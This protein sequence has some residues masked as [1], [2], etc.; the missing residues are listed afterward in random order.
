MALYINTNIWSLNA[1]RALATSQAELTR[2]LE[3]LSTTLRINRASDD[4]TGHAITER[5]TSQ[6]NGVDQARRNVSHGTIFAQHAESNLESINARLQEIRTKIVSANEGSLA[7][8]QRQALQNEVNVLLSEVERIAQTAEFDGRKVLNGT[9]TNSVF[10]VGPNAADTV[11]V[12]TNDFRS[13]S[14][15]VYRVIGNASGSGP[16]GKNR[17][18]EKMTVSGALGASGPFD[19]AP[20]GIG[21]GARRIAEQVNGVSS[22]TGVTATAKT[23]VDIKGWVDGTYRLAIESDNVANPLSFDF[24]VKAALP[25][26]LLAFDLSTAVALFNQSDVSLQSGVVMSLNKAYLDGSDSAV[27]GITLTNDKGSNIAISN[28]PASVNPGTKLTISGS[29]DGVAVTDTVT[30]DLPPAE[31]NQRIFTGQVIFDSDKPFSIR[32][33]T[34]DADYTN[35]RSLKDTSATSKFI[36]EQAKVVPIANIDITTLEGVR[37]AFAIVDGA[38]ST[39]AN[40]RASLGSVKNRFDWIISNLDSDFVNLSTARGYIRDADVAL[41]TSIQTRASIQQQVNIAILGQ[42]NAL[43]QAVLALLR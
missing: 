28:K 40:Q 36:T 35:T 20:A 30:A 24:G 17:L 12:N 42:A 10:Q 34:T 22:K 21:T 4:P 43:Q 27:A 33:E 31:P 23:E 6:I 37:E 19:I 13:A 3:R 9:F 8:P 25:G 2:S 39:V 41:E 29:I 38:L 7:F 11:S 15:G 18:A 14:L 32:G 16:S 1:Q 5:Y 26:S